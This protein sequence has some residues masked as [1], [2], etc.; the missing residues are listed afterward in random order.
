[1]RYI[2]FF[3]TSL[4]NMIKDFTPARSSVATGFIWKPRIN[5]TRNRYRPAQLSYENITYSG[6]GVTTF[7]A[8]SSFYN[9]E[10]V[11]QDSGS[12][13]RPIGL[14]GEKY[15]AQADGSTVFGT[16]SFPGGTGGTFDASNLPRFNPDGSGGNFNSRKNLQTPVTGLNQKWTEYLNAQSGA[17]HSKVRNDQSEFYSGDFRQSGLNG[18]MTPGFG[19]DELNGYFSKE[20]PFEKGSFVPG[21]GS[22]QFAYNNNPK[23]LY[24]IT[25]ADGTAIENL[26]MST[27]TNN[28]EL[29]NATTD[30]IY[31]RSE[32][33]IQFKLIYIKVN[34]IA[35]GLDV[36]L[37]VGDT[38]NITPTAGAWSGSPPVLAIPIAPGGLPQTVGSSQYVAYFPIGFTGFYEQLFGLTTEVTF[39][40]PPSP[41]SFTEKQNWPYSEFNP[42]TGNS[43]DPSAGQD[44]YAGIRKGTLFQDADYSPSADD[45]Y[46]PINIDLIASGSASRAAVPDSNFRSDWWSNVRYMGSRVSSPD[47]N[48]RI[49]KAVDDISL[50]FSSESIGIDYNVSESNPQPPV[51][52]PQNPNR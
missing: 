49:V 8:W 48:Q 19:A 22:G 6:S 23:N 46:T 35:G 50:V 10:G 41:N 34:Q 15:F 18:L 1:M 5:D 33:L 3:D 51:D 47:F 25:S 45:P 21:Q 14:I 11:Q 2:K 13:T 42:L 44:S 31:Y 24:K 40:P 29:Q 32:G 16:A 39:F 38:L 36:L 37:S 30:L 26:T 12:I 7:N 20:L 52:P 27:V 9:R 43:F 28:E 17:L 4:F